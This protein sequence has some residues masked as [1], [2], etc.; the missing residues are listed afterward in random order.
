M[1]LPELTLEGS[2]SPGGVC[3]G[4]LMCV[5][6]SFPLGSIVRVVWCIRALPVGVAFFRVHHLLGELVCHT[7]GV[8]L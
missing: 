4:G 3:F 1:F 8:L 2:F 6:L 5:C 7:V